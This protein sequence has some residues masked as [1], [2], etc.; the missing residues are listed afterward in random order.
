MSI[1]RAWTGEVWV[2]STTPES[3]DSTKNVSGLGPGRVVGG[4][5]EGVEV[6]PLGL[7]LGSLG[8]LPAH[9]DE[10][11]ADA[12]LQRRERVAGTGRTSVP[13]QRDVDGLV[14]EHPGVAGRLELG[15][16]GRQGLGHGAAR[17]ADPPAGL[18]PGRR[19]QRADLAV[20]QGQ[21]RAVAGVLEARP[22]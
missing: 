5:V 10:D 3:A 22:A 13:R 16:A 19:G 14:D 21:R 20:G 15:L 18:G 6:E 7:D 2:R 4:D 11:V 1:A 12:L 9:R 17:G 8:D